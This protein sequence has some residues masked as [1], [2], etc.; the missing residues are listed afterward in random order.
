MAAEAGAVKRIA[1]GLKAHSGWA[2]LVALAE[3]DGDLEVV[4]RHRV[5]LVEPADLA[6][7]K[8][9]YHAASGLAPDDARDVVARAMAAARRHAVRALRE[10]R[11]RAWRVEQ[12]IAAVAVLTSDPMPDWSVAEILAVHFRMHKAEGVLF[13]DALA[14]AAGTCRLPL[15]AIVEKRLGDHAERALAQPR[16][17]VQAAIAALG[18]GLGPPWGRD[19][20]DA[21]LA[22]WIGLRER[23]A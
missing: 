6:W 12:E 8:Q 13:R 4:D 20:K 10:E 5:E 2:A 17:R 11:T 22:A 1:L 16:A 23:S 14:R 15:V 3:H 18:A 9:P 7:A 19:Q 21:A